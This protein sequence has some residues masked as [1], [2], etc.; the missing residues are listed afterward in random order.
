MCFLHY[1]GDYIYIEKAMNN[2]TL[3]AGQK[4]ILRCRITGVPKPR[5]TWYKN[6]AEI[7]QSDRRYKGFNIRE[8]DWGS[9]LTIKNVETTDIGYYTCKAESGAGTLS[10]TGILFA[11]LGM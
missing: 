6:D 1:R 8:Y 4:A 2:E 11:R 5:Y 10:T 7:T 3:F 9:K